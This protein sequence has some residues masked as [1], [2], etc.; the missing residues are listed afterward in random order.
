MCG[1]GLTLLLKILAWSKLKIIT[2]D[3]LKIAETKEFVFKG[4]EKNVGKG[5][6]LW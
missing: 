3:K 5:E 1:N 6:K 4:V 2:D